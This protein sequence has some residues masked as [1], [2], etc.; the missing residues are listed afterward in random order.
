MKNMQCKNKN[1][2]KYFEQK[3]IKDIN[4]YNF[5]NKNSKIYN[6]FFYNNNELD[7]EIYLNIFYYLIY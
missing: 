1:F 2:F 5:M 3:N 7:N 6:I 4:L